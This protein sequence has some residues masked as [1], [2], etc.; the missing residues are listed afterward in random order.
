MTKEE[1]CIY[2][3]VKN[4]LCKRY[5]DQKL[6]KTM[7]TIRWLHRLKMSLERSYHGCMIHTHD[8]I[9]NKS[10][11][12]VLVREALNHAVQWMLIYEIQTYG[13]TIIS[14]PTKLPNIIDV[15]TLLGKRD[16]LH[17]YLPSIFENQRFIN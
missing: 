17:F 12:V 8:Q 10:R 9:D 6:P 11:N 13:S 14:D 15:K 5:C 16:I 7:V 4:T 3:L 1:N 2:L